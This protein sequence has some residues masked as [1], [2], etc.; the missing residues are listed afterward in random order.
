L[1]LAWQVTENS[2]S[3]PPQIAPWPDTMDHWMEF[4]GDGVVANQDDPYQRQLS[5]NCEHADRG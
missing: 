2:S 1:A 5:S 3:K 4:F